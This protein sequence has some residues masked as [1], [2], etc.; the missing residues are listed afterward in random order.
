MLLRATATFVSRRPEVL[1]ALA[2]I[3][4]R[5][6]DAEA[7]RA[8]FDRVLGAPGVSSLM[9]GQPRDLPSFFLSSSE[10]T[11][12]SCAVLHPPGR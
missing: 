9:G 5:S 2:R 12:V 10:R 11:F 6:G 7:A 4:E 3:E 1:L 8:V